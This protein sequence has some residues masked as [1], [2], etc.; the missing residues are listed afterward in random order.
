MK[1]LLKR[2]YW[3]E[4]K[5]W[6]TRQIYRAFNKQAKVE[7]NRENVLLRKPIWFFTNDERV[8][9]Y[10]VKNRAFKWG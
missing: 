9:S 7:A 5:D 1:G 3:D 10:M 2:N 4:M 8:T 6:R